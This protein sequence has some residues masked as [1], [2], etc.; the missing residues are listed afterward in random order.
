MTMRAVNLARESYSNIPSAPI[1]SAS[2]SAPTDPSP[3][4]SSG[5]TRSGS[6]TA[7]SSGR[8]PF[9]VGPRLLCESKLCRLKCQVISAINKI[10]K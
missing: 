1:V 8:K 9:Q 3:P 2:R 5:R 6:E 7:R 4:A 10:L